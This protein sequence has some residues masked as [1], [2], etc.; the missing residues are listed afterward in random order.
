MRMRC[1]DDIAEN[2]GRE[3]LE[4]EQER[5]NYRLRPQ[6]IINDSHSL[7]LNIYHCPDCRLLRIR[8]FLN[9]LVAVYLYIIRNTTSL[10]TFFT[11]Q[12]GLVAI[13]ERT[14]RL[15]RSGSLILTLIDFLILNKIFKT[16][17]FSV[18]TQKK[19]L[20]GDSIV[21]LQTSPSQTCFTVYCWLPR[22][23]QCFGVVGSLFTSRF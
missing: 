19:K 11:R 12:V 8:R 17:I 16:D 10:R 21:V 5:F 1:D 4:A 13:T 22:K 7:T 15:S 2:R 20:V 14:S 18:V 9:H 6:C 23:R 3:E